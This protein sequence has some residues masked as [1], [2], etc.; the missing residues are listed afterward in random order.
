V[1]SRMFQLGAQGPVICASGQ[2]Y[3]HP[4]WV[5]HT[6]HSDTKSVLE[7]RG[8]SGFEMVIRSDGTAGMFYHRRRSCAPS[9][10]PSTPFP[11]SSRCLP[12][13]IGPLT[14]TTTMG[15]GTTSST[16]PSPRRLLRW[17]SSHTLHP[18]LSRIH[19]PPRL[20]PNH[21]VPSSRLHPPGRRKTPALHRR[22]RRQN[23]VRGPRDKRNTNGCR[24]LPADPVSPSP[25]HKLGD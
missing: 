23:R 6:H 8:R 14:S 4:V 11:V 12:T 13:R 5:F 2:V 20:V 21:Y 3:P 22:R 15:R 19:P 1:D 17:E 24:I 10:Q 7:C 9:H 25:S 18:R 16:S